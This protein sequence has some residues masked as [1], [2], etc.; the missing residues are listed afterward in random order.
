M[1]HYNISVSVTPNGD[2][3]SERNN[4]IV[5]AD[6]KSE[7]LEKGIIAYFARNN[8]REINSVKA[9]YNG[10]VQIVDES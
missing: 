8:V 6:N 5:N 9:T 4:F 2:Y 1:T 7:A 10:I 3:E